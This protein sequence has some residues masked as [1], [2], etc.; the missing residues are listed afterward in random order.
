MT[1]VIIVRHWH[2]AADAFLGSWKPSRQFLLFLFRHTTALAYKKAIIVA[3]T[4]GLP[5]LFPFPLLLSA[6]LDSP[7]PGPA[8]TFP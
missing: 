3:D 6:L 8:L 7:L 1:C 4:R 2:S 5:F